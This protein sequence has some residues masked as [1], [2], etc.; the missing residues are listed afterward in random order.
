MAKNK[1]L[2]DFDGFQGMMDAV[3]DS[4][5]AELGDGTIDAP[6]T[7]ALTK[8]P[9]G[10]IPGGVNATI[11]TAA[12]ERISYELAL[13]SGKALPTGNPLVDSAKSEAM[14]RLHAGIPANSGPS[15][16]LTDGVRIRVGKHLATMLFRQATRRLKTPIAAEAAA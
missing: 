4:L 16:E 15:T 5:S 2:I 11:N 3:Y 9:G 1:S 6:D 14:N 10:Y 8:I 12:Q 7:W 13:L